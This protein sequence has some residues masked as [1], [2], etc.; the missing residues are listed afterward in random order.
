[1]TAFSYP[2]QPIRRGHIRQR[3]AAPV[4]KISQHD[5]SIV[6]HQICI[7]TQGWPSFCADLKEKQMLPDSCMCPSYGTAIMMEPSVYITVQHMRH[8]ALVKNQL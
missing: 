2:I 6:Q 1:M 3:Q 5:A 4:A 8:E 7:R